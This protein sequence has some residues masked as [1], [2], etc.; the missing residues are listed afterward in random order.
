MSKKL[1]I[2]VSVLALFSALS[3]GGFGCV[4]APIQLRNRSFNS[5]AANWTGTAA[6]LNYTFDTAN[7]A[8]RSGCVLTLKSVSDRPGSASTYEL[9]LDT[10]AAFVFF[11]VPPGLYE[12]KILKCA[13]GTK[14]ELTDFLKGRFTIASGRINFLGLSQFR[15]SDDTRGLSVVQGGQK[16]TTLALAQDLKVLPKGWGTWIFDPFTAKPIVADMLVLKQDYSL[17]VHTRNTHKRGEAASLDT[18]SLVEA[19]RACDLR[20]QSRFP[21]RLGTILTVADYKD[22]ELKNL[23][24]NGRNSFSDEF[25]E[26]LENSLRGFKTEAG[27]SVEVKLT[28]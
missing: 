13:D 15:F 19:V 6:L 27:V 25:T 20:E 1:L 23:E 5:D 18:K 17:N 11:E 28:L 21:Y 3:L 4:T 22:G 2:H 24:E 9:A 12:A 7:P 16:A 8:Q 14:W 26:C 10:Q